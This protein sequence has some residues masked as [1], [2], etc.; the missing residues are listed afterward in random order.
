[1]PGQQFGVAPA[2]GQSPYALTAARRAVTAGVV[3]VRRG[4]PPPTA[5]IEVQTTP[6][7]RAL[8]ALE[9]QQRGP[10][11]RRQAEPGLCGALASTL[12]P[13]LVLLALVRRA[14]PRPRSAVWRRA[15]PLRTLRLG[16][17]PAVHAHVLDACGA[18]SAA[19]A[20]RCGAHAPSSGVLVRAVNA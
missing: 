2:A 3:V 18:S 15:R 13:G 19:T 6:A 10:L 17:R 5:P 11:P 1:Y 14:P 8:V 4:T 20:G 7:D 9:R 16:E 12:A